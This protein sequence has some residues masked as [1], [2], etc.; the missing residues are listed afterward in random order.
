LCMCE[1]RIQISMEGVFIAPDY[2]VLGCGEGLRI[3]PVSDE[4]EDIV[5][6]P[7]RML[8]GPFQLH[9]P[10]STTTTHPD[11][12]S[13]PITSVQEDTA[14]TD[15]PNKRPRRAAAVV[16]EQRMADVFTW[17]KCKE[18]SS[19]FKNAAIQINAEFDRVGGSKRKRKNCEEEFVVVAEQDS[20]RSVSPVAVLEDPVGEPV[21]EIASDDEG[22]AD[23]D[24]PDVDVHNDKKDDLEDEEDESGSLASFVV[25]DSYV[26]DVDNGSIESVHDDS[27]SDHSVGGASESE[28]GSDSD[29]D[30]TFSC[31]DDSD[32]DGTASDQDED[33]CSDAAVKP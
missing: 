17:E 31:A 22:D 2:D 13:P 26:S 21:I 6:D 16:A 33:N 23:V 9:D 4:E 11:V 19:M 8:M 15:V 14:A 32:A 25:S 10:R 5:M 7:R 28:C 12:V 18:S 29:S 20:S 1:I 27:G 24:C 30:G 3:E